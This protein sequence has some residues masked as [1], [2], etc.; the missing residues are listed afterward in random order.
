VL[1][2]GKG[3]ER[4]QITGSAALPFDDRQAAAEELRALGY[5]CSG[6]ARRAGESA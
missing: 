5:D 6:A 1:L 3:H 2:A 4:V